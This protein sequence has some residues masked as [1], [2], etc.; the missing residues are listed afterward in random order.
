[1]T[2]DGYFTIYTYISASGDSISANASDPEPDDLSY[3]S[4]FVDAAEPT[5]TLSGNNYFD[6]GTGTSFSS[7]SIPLGSNYSAQFYFLLEVYYSP[8]GCFYGDD[9]DECEGTTQEGYDAP[10]GYASVYVP[11]PPPMISS[12]SRYSAPQGDQGTLTIT[13]TNFIQ[14]ASDQLSLEFSGSSNPFTLT[15]APSQ[16]TTACTA[17]FSYNLSGYPTGT[18]NLWLANDE[19]ES[20][21][22]LFTVYSPPQTLPANPCAITSDPKSSFSSI[23]S[24]GTPGSGSMT[25]SFS[26]SA[27]AN[28]SLTV[29]HGPYST[30]SSIASHI[31]ALITKNYAQYG[32]LAKALGP[33]II[34]SGTS[35]LGT[36][37]ISG[38]S[39]FTTDTSAAAATATANACYAIPKLPCAGSVGFWNYDIPITYNRGKPGE[40]TETAREHIIRRHIAN[41][42]S[43][44][45]T[46]YA[47]PL[48]VPTNA[49][50]DQVWRWNQLT[51]WRSAGTGGQYEFTWPS[52]P[53]GNGEYRL[54]LIGNDVSGNDL[55]SNHLT[56]SL[57]KCSVI[58]SY[59]VGP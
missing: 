36:V 34:Y 48:H 57:D 6:S 45:T 1:M 56:V 49:M 43:V 30:P 11:G 46:V 2:D 50:F 8:D 10:T 54:E 37:N 5:W 53:L 41:T 38:S 35:A 39:S 13:G 27:F 22:E 51:Y 47:N 9:S 25:V 24:T 29:T 52:I 33:N 44:G 14:N 32:L 7:G 12:L 19:A 15:S 16:C 58:T 17:T 23:I 55:H 42:A 40:K 4:F 28:I 21:P 31:A 20:E 59:P 18:Y 3:F 26:G